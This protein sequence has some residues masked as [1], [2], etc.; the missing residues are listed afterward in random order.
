MAVHRRREEGKD[1]KTVGG[2]NTKKEIQRKKTSRRE[3]EREI[4]QPTAGADREGRPKQ[5]LGGWSL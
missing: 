1:V 3:R 4:I 5:G 2:R